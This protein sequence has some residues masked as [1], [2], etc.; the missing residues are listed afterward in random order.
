MSGG[1]EI[2]KSAGWL[3]TTA[4]RLALGEQG[5]VVTALQVGYMDTEMGADFDAPKA[6]PGDIAQ[7]TVDAI[8]SGD[9]EILADDTTRS[10]K[11]RLSGDLTALYPRLAAA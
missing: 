7:R 6:D 9:D 8:M 11:S 2:S 4:L 5:T 1:Y 10:V 3:A